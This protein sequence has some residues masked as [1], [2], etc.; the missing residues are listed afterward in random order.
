[1]LSHEVVSSGVFRTRIVIQGASSDSSPILRGTSVVRSGEFAGSTDSH[2]QATTHT[3]DALGRLTRCDYPDGTYLSYSYDARGFVH[4]CRLLDGETRTLDVDAAGRTTRVTSSDPAF[5]VTEYRWDSRGRL[6]WASQGSTTVTATYDSTGNQT[7]ETCDDTPAGLPPESFTIIRTFDARGRTGIIYPD[8]RHFLEE[9]DELG[10]LI[11]ISQADGSGLPLSPPIVEITYLG[12]R[13]AATTQANGVATQYEY[14]GDGDA[15]APGGPDASFGDVIST[16]VRK[17][18][19]TLLARVTQRR[20]PDQR[21]IARSIV[22]SEGAEASGRRHEYLL[23]DVGQLIGRMTERRESSGGPWIPESSVSYELDTEGN[24]LTATGGE[25]PGSYF[26][27]PANPPGDLAMH[28]YSTWPRGHLEWDDNG[29]ILNV[30]TDGGVLAF[31]H[32][33]AGRLTACRPGVGAPPLVT[34][35]Y[36]ALDRRTA[37]IEYDGSGTPISRVRYVHDG[38]VCI[39]EWSD[40][41]SGTPSAALTHVASNGIRHCIS[42]RAGTL[43][44]PHGNS[45]QH[46]GDPHVELSHTMSK[47]NTGAFTPSGDFHPPTLIADASGSMLEGTDCDDAGKFIFLGASGLPT[48]SNHPI[49]PIRWMA[50]EQLL[51]DTIGLV[52]GTGVVYSPDLGSVVSRPKKKAIPAYKYQRTGHVTLMK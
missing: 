51:D 47:N 8:G 25:H 21:V 10:R 39:Q 24:R 28:Q 31:D 5:P 12:H 44:Y 30:E 48:G 22:W 33:T 2:G 36:D 29:N 34:Y 3:R 16:S 27:N 14:R 17:G 50:P 46:W 52:L 15:P 4:Q 26:Q 13:V 35:E 23:D 6:R 18:D 42:T 49:G 41:G 32:D 19:S 7:T 1:M 11:S 40:D 9:R 37:R 43:Y 45:V 38:S 20:A